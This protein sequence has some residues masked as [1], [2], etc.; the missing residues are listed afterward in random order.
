VYAGGVTNLSVVFNYI[1]VGSDGTT[2]VA[3]GARGVWLTDA[4]AVIGGLTSDSRNVISGNMS[5]GVFF[6]CQASRVRVQANYIG[7][8]ATGLTALGNGGDG[9]YADACTGVVI[10]DPVIAGAG[11]VISANAGYGVWL[12][13]GTSKC[14]VDNNIIGKR[15]DGKAMAGFPNALGS[16]RDDGVNNTWGPG[17][18]MA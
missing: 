14:T 7:V 13:G 6:Q 9:I 10:G 4:D 3:N 12:A 18:D 5:S 1:G 2:K 15:S 16:K 11:N 17:N 8:D